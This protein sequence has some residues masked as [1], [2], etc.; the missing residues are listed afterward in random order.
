MASSSL[1][2]I[3]KEE[4]E[5]SV[6]NP[7][8]SINSK[9]TLMRPISKTKEEVKSGKRK[10]MLT[11]SQLSDLFCRLDKSGDGQLDLEEFCHIVKVLKLG[12]SEEFIADVFHMVDSSK[13]GSLDMKEFI[14]AYQKIYSS[15]TRKASSFRSHNESFIRATRYGFN[16]F[17]KAIFE[18]F[19]IP[20][21][22]KSEKTT[23]TTATEQEI[24]DQSKDLH[25]L[26][27]L[28]EA[29]TDSTYQF[30]LSDINAMIIVDTIKNA[31]SSSKILWWVDIS[32]EKVASTSVSKFTIELGLPNN[33]KFN[34][35]LN[36]FDSQINEKDIAVVGEGSVIGAK[37]VD[38]LTFFVQTAWLKDRPI[39]H[40][41]PKMFDFPC[42]SSWQIGRAVSNYYASRFAFLF[43]LA[44]LSDTRAEESYAAYRS[45]ETLA[46]RLRG[47]DGDDENFESARA[48]ESKSKG[49]F[50]KKTIDSKS[51]KLFDGR[52]LVTDRE[53][54][55]LGHGQRASNPQW[56]QPSSQISLRTPTL[57]YEKLSLSVLDQSYGPYTLVTIRQINT[58]GNSGL[59]MEQASRI[60]AIGRIL[61]GMWIKLYQVCALEHGRSGDVGELMDSPMALAA[62]IMASVNNFS[63]NALG[64]LEYWLDQVDFGIKDLVVSKHS[65]HL[66]VIDRLLKELSSYS[67]PYGTL[68]ANLMTGIEEEEL[69]NEN[70]LPPAP[71][72]EDK[73][74]KVLVSVK[75]QRGLGYGRSIENKPITFKTISKFFLRDSHDAYRDLSRL[76]EGCEALE[77]KGLTYMNNRIDEL[78]ELLESCKTVLQAQMDEKRNL[79]SFA[80]T[81]V[82]TML[83]PLAILTGYWGMNFDNMEEL[84]AETYP[85]ETAPGIRI[86]WASTGAIY[87]AMI[88]FALHF[89]IF[90]SAT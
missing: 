87:V 1:D 46:E 30:E 14:S 73:G 6:D 50:S 65:D 11:S 70:E 55:F 12:A 58:E 40:H 28:T 20:S 9:R 79:I 66:L 78:K 67:Q 62:L 80:L 41:L 18:C 13:N 52:C 22:G 10:Q 88:L 77:V 72:I 39:A 25:Y 51:S 3:Y 36:G 60:G 61:S 64:A 29:E 24:G 5:Y 59:T 76:S 17:G 34:A 43:N 74:S 26:K 71:K 81:I 19:T 7:G 4:A 68:I 8:S 37:E 63:L 42:W 89:R 56:L 48:N 69:E 31:E 23:L 32:M 38:S 90:Y 53:R 16:E 44:F 57:Q 35:C 49:F 83:A 33:S 2:S 82:T 47:D 85:F 27:V 15:S 54:N 86:M 84:V 21:T 45:A 75:S